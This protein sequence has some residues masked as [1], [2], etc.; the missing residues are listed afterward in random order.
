MNLN[1]SPCSIPQVR[2]ASSGPSATPNPDFLFECGDLDAYSDI[3]QQHLVAQATSGSPI[4]TF[5]QVWH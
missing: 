1:G 2:E 3:V 4:G 5:V